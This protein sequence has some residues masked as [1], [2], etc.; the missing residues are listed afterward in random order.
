M[1]LHVNHIAPRRPGASHPRRAGR[2]HRPDAARPGRRRGHRAATGAEPAGP[3]GLDPVQGELPGAGPRPARGRPVRRAPRPR[4]ARGG[5]PPRRARRPRRGARSGAR[6]RRGSGR[7]GP[8]GRSRPRDVDA[9]PGQRDLALQP[10]L[11]AARGGLGG[12]LRPPVRGGAP[13]RAIGRQ[14][15]PTRWRTRW[16][17]S[18]RSCATSRSG[19]SS[20]PRSSPSRSVWARASARRSGSTGSG[21]STR[22]AGPATTR[23]S[24]FSSGT[25]RCPRSIGRWTRSPPT[26]TS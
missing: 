13:Q 1:I 24:G 23:A 10:A 5:P 7:G 8:G 11:L 4:R 14:A 22:S 17:T 12:R 16:P 21:L 25:T 3:P 6:R 2:G 19:D 15:R 20:R 18:G 9:D 26:G